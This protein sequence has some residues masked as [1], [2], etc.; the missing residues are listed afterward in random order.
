MDGK[1]DGQRE[2]SIPPANICGGGGWGGVGI[3]KKENA[4]MLD[5]PPKKKEV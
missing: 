5:L 4:K 1:T 2:N 3:K